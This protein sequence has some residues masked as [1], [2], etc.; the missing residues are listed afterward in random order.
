[1]Q[2]TSVVPW[3]EPG[4]KQGTPNLTKEM[5]AVLLNMARYKVQPTRG[6]P[7][8]WRLGEGQKTPHG[9][10]TGCYEILHMVSELARS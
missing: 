1:M 6:G 5:Y 2:C 4:C 8:A 10:I 3:H 9:E 7:A